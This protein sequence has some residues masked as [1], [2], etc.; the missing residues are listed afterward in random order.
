MCISQDSSEK[1]YKT[2]TERYKQIYYRNWLRWWRLRSTMNLLSANLRSR[3][4]ACVIQ[5]ES[6]DLRTGS[7]KDGGQEKVEVPAQQRENVLFLS[8][9][10][11]SIQ[12]FKGLDD[13]HPCW[14]SPPL[15]ETPSQTH[16]ETMSYQLSGHPLPQSGWHIK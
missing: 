10:V 12:A 13:A 1:I 8:L 5:C 7:T 14:V 4:P 6:K 11:L 3:T 16:L 2:W 9:F 15:L